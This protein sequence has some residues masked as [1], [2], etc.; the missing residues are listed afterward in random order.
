MFVGSVNAHNSILYLE[1]WGV[2][3]NRPNFSAILKISACFSEARGSL[4]CCISLSS[5]KA[6]SSSGRSP[7]VMLKPFPTT[8]LTRALSSIVPCAGFVLSACPTIAPCAPRDASIYVVTTSP[9]SIIATKNE[10]SALLQTRSKVDSK[11]DIRLLRLE[12]LI[13]TRVRPICC[14]TYN[15]LDELSLL[16][17]GIAHKSRDLDSCAIPRLKSINFA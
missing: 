14:T 1:D 15:T 4:F 8:E 7:S 10:I 6:L 11:I 16:F 12:E 9:C 3:F 13:T 2:S 5:S 17:L